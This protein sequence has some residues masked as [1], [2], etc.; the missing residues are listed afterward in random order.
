MVLVVEVVATT[1]VVEV[2][3]QPLAAV[4]EV[5]APATSTLA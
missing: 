2:V 3:L 1:A 4:V 5:V